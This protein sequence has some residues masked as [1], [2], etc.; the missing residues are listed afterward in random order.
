MEKV[1]NLLNTND[2]NRL[3]SSYFRTLTYN[4]ND[5]KYDNYSNM[6]EYLLNSNNKLLDDIYINDDFIITQCKNHMLC[7]TNKTNK[8]FFKLYLHKIKNITY[9]ISKINFDINIILSYIDEN[10]IELKQ[11]E[12]YYYYNKLCIIIKEKNKYI[13]KELDKYLIKDLNNIIK[14]YYSN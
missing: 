7:R 12:N 14:S 10:I 13:E 2:F 1:Q 3:L 11:L 5:Y 6:I 8:Y 9:V 4:M